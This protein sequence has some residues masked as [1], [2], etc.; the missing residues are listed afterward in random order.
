MFTLIHGC[1]GEGSLPPL[2]IWH[3][4]L[5]ASWV[6]SSLWKGW[7]EEE[8]EKVWH[9][10]KFQKTGNADVD[11]SR[12]PSHPKMCPT[13]T[14]TQWK[15][16]FLEDLGTNRWAVIFVSPL[17]FSCIPLPEAAST[18]PLTFASP[19][20]R[21]QISTQVR[22]M[23]ALIFWTT[24]M[25]IKGY[26]HPVSSTLYIRWG[27]E[28]SLLGLNSQCETKLLKDLP[29]HP[30]KKTYNHYLLHSTGF[31]TLPWPVRGQQFIAYLE[32]RPLSSL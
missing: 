5:A 15:R 11:T 28:S 3:F 20:V 29:S 22:K 17:P 25:K 14:W 4:I 19:I 2:Y 6:D 10:G 9:Y 1:L 26:T 21:T 27:R 30:D 32:R 7:L 12:N 23:F 13:V 24:R 16:A 31:I 8:D 18:C